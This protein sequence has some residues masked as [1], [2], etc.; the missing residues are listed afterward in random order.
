MIPKLTIL[1]WVFINGSLGLA[2]QARS[3]LRLD[4]QQ[5]KAVPSAFQLFYSE[6]FLFQALLQ[7]ESSSVWF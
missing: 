3:Q 2:F 6:S 1:E 4:W 5:P 7:L